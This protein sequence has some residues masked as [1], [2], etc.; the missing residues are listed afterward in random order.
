M[1][2]TCIGKCQN[3]S[4]TTTMICIVNHSFCNVMLYPASQTHKMLSTGFTQ[5]NAKL[6]SN[7]KVTS[8]VLNSKLRPWRKCVET[9]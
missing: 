5:I 9:Q 1:T 6:N 2:N 4:S 7:V 3:I 8:Q